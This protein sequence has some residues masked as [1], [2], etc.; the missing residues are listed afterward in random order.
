MVWWLAW[1]WVLVFVLA[2]LSG[3]NPTLLVWVIC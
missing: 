3:D 1:R 2:R